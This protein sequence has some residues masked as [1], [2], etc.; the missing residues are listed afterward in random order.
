MPRTIKAKPVTK[1]DICTEPEIQYLAN[2]DLFADVQ[3]W[4][5]ERGGIEKKSERD[6]AVYYDTKNFRLLREGIEYRVKE[7]GKQFRHDMKTPCDTHV[8]EVVPDANDIL[9]RKELKFKTDA[10]KPNLMAF[11]ALA[12]LQ[13]VRDR[14][15]RFFD[16]ELEAKVRSSFFKHKVDHETD[17]RRARVEYS[18]QTGNMESADGRRKTKLLHILEL[19]L[20]EGMDEGLL[21]EKAELERLFKP[22]GLVLLPDRKLLMGFELIKPDM[23]AKQRHAYED[24]KKRNRRR[25]GEETGQNPDSVLYAVA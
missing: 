24:A 7:K 18:F 13:P 15:F 3:Q 25:D 1:I 5:M 17:C 22:K 16:K 20:R 14:V 11:N 8:R 9:W 12:L 2:A 10:E 19:E 4:L 21:E 23:D 6:S